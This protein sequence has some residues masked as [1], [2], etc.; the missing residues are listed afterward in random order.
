METTQAVIRVSDTF[1]L[2]FLLMGKIA[3][4]KEEVVNG[5]Y[6]AEFPREKAVEAIHYLESSNLMLFIAA[7]QKTQAR[8]W[9]MRK[10]QRDRRLSK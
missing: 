10:E 3:P 9:T 1:Q 2:A 4:L 7:I 8:I 5:R 6:Y